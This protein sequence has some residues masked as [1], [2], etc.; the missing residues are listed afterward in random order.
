METTPSQAWEAGAQNSSPATLFTCYVSS[1]KSFS[2]S[3]PQCFALKIKAPRFFFF[4]FSFFKFIHSERERA[5]ES[6]EATER[7]RRIPGGLY[8][9]I[10]QF[11]ARTHE[12]VRS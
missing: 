11:G 8:T 1:D 7:E 9:D 3:R 10:P 5:R 4:C 2:L 6:G 12:P